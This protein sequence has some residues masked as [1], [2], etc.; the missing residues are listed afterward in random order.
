MSVTGLLKK[1]NCSKSK[2]ARPRAGALR[3]TS[4]GPN[5]QGQLEAAR[6]KYC[7]TYCICKI[8]VIMDYIYCLSERENHFHV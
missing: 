6:Q 7:D 4:L 1:R 5:K 2:S 8:H 3:M